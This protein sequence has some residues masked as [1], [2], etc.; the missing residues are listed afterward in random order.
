MKT[1]N[2]LLIAAILVIIVSMVTYDFALR[3]EY[4]KGEY[5][6]RFYEKENLGF[7]GFKSIDNRAANYLTLSV[8]RGD[9]FEVWV[10]K[11]L[12]DRIKISKIGDQLIVDVMDRK[13]PKIVFYGNTIT[14]ICPS[15]NE[16]TTQPLWLVKEDQGIYPS[17]ATT[18]LSGF[19]QQNLS[20]IVKEFTHLN[21]EKTKIEN[22]NATVGNNS[23][24]HAYLFIASN[25]QIGNANINVLGTNQLSIENPKI[26]KTNFTISDSANVNFSGSILKQLRT[27]PK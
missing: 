19:N 21:L 9:H 25:N 2:K 5:K 7:K 27:Q 4:V 1:S 17:D 23:S 13:S 14:I 8:E 16:I 3:A 24:T 15:I 22:L 12:K 10:D 6:N 18:S 26:N 20:L 11:N